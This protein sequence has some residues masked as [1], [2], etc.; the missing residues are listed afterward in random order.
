MILLILEWPKYIH[1]FKVGY[2]HA[3][4]DVLEDFSWGM[5]KVDFLR[6]FSTLWFVEKTL[7]IIPFFKRSIKEYTQKTD[8]AQQRNTYELIRFPG[9]LFFLF[10]N[11]ITFLHT[12]ETFIYLFFNDSQSVPRNHAIGTNYLLKKVSYDICCIFG[13]DK[14][15]YE[16]SVNAAKLY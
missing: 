8:S 7:E 3:V 5:K 11:I 16:K 1:I 14:C 4:I 2:G 13:L 12:T 15:L 6:I 9:E 10:T